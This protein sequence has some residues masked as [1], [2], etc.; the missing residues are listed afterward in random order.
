MRIALQ[1]GFQRATFDSLFS[2]FLVLIMF[3]VTGT[4]KSYADWYDDEIYQDSYSDYDGYQDDEE[5][6]GDELDFLSE[7]SETA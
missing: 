1:H 7:S 3:L 6:A 4:F 5:V 2:F